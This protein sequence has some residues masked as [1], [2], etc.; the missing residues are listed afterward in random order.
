MEAKRRALAL[1]GV[2]RGEA[3][4]VHVPTA[5]VEHI[6][7]GDSDDDI[8]V[9]CALLGDADYIVTYELSFTTRN[10]LRTLAD[11][12]P[13]RGVRTTGVQALRER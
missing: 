6:V 7:E 10:L 8:I 4:W 5:S 11:T 3:D 1:K 9:A 2:P 12:R 13:A